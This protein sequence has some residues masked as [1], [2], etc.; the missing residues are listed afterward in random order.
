MREVWGFFIVVG[1]V[2]LGK[3]LP[4]RLKQPNAPT[5]RNPDFI[6][7]KVSHFVPLQVKNHLRGPPFPDL[8]KYQGFCQSDGGDFQAAGRPGE[9]FKGRRR[10]DHE[11]HSIICCQLLGDCSGDFLLISGGRGVKVIFFDMIFDF[12]RTFDD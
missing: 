12:S 4:I 3:L 8:S 1:L 6:A 2:W 10:D 11:I 7:P 5:L 9:R